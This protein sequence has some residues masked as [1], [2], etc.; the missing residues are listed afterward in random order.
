MSSLLYIISMEIP[1]RKRGVQRDHPGA[2]MEGM[3]PGSSPHI[4]GRMNDR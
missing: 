2:V 4:N 3:L 1:G